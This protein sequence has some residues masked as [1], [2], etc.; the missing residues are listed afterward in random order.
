MGRLLDS[1]YYCFDIK[2]PAKVRGERGCGNFHCLW[3]S[4]N[5]SCTFLIFA[6]SFSNL[7]FPW[8]RNVGMFFQSSNTRYMII[9]VCENWCHTET[10]HGVSISKLY[11][12]WLSPTCL[13]STLPKRQVDR[14]IQLP[15]LCFLSLF[16]FSF[17]YS[18]RFYIC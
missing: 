9:Q 10:R 5:D 2:L 16:L 4:V 18:M 11:G 6:S 14:Y 12:W 15:P 13:Q 17:S 8:I 7:L 1:R 3:H